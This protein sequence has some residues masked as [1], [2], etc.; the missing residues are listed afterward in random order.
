MSTGESGTVTAYD[1]SS[2]L[3][4]V[5][6]HSGSTPV[7]TD[8]GTKYTLKADAKEITA[9][10]YADT[11]LSGDDSDTTNLLVQFQ[12]GPKPGDSEAQMPVHERLDLHIPLNQVLRPW[13][14]RLTQHVQRNL[15]LANKRV[16]KA[17]KLVKALKKQLKEAKKHKERTSEYAECAEQHTEYLEQ[18]LPGVAGAGCATTD[19][20][21]RPF[22]AQCQPET[23]IAPAAAPPS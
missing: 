20:Y 23:S 17:D 14:N 19:G 1:N 21:T 13:T 9:Q 22:C 16:R 10:D 8:V 11:H 5:S 6:W 7:A 3:V 15:N 2:K 4:E 18:E 12:I